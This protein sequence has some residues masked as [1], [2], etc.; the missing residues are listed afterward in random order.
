MI[1]IVNPIAQAW[2]RLLTEQGIPIRAHLDITYRCD[3]DCEH[4]YLDDKDDRRELATE[5]WLRVV[6]ELADWGVQR[7]GWSGGEVFA[8]ADFFT[9]LEHSVRRGFIN[10]IKTHAGNIDRDLALRLRALDVQR[11]DI[12]LYSLSA[13]VHDG[14]T[15]I[16]GSLSATLRGIAALRAVGHIVSVQVMPFRAN[17]LEIED[18][19]AF[20]EGL[21]C[22]A[23]IAPGLK[24]D[25]GGGLAVLDLDLSYEE[26]IELERI[27][28]RVALRQGHKGWRPG[29]VAAEDQPCE[30][31]TGRIYF[32]PDGAIFPCVT[33]PSAIGHVRS[34]PIR[35]QWDASPLRRQLAA[36]TNAKRTS[37]LSCGASAGCGYCAGA[38]FKATGD[39]DVAPPY[40]H[41]R[42]RAKAVAYELERGVALGDAFWASVPTGEA[43]V[44][45]RRGQFP[46]FRA[47]KTGKA[48]LAAGE[49]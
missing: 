27:R 36:W 43:P 14:I 12:S 3:L 40:F 9:L 25:N 41:E 6:D 2:Q 38:A 18:M 17:M 7:L 13:P 48:A 21:G 46:I 39:H 49:R 47:Q 22:V 4:C 16:P 23:S 42:S 19:I 30:I 31:G 8:R 15:R 11:I 34:G 35:A 37:C 33:Y 29:V 26:R 1:E 44:V 10:I 20:L 5:E 32:G 24:A 28:L 45:K